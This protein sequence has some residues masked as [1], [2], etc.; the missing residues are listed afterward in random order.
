[1]PALGYERS[2]A[3]Y[4]DIVE[5]GMK[6][7]NGLEVQLLR[8]GNGTNRKRRMCHGD[9]C[10]RDENRFG[11]ISCLKARRRPKVEITA[12]RG[13]VCLDGS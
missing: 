8:G 12:R 5:S 1:M 3:H 13:V 10:Y 7:G 6:Q 4:A 2:I 11:L 9:D